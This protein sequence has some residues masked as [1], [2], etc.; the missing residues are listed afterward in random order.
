M[1]AGKLGGY[2]KTFFPSQPVK[3]YSRTFFKPD[4]KGIVIKYEN[5]DWEIR[6]E[7]FTKMDVLEEFLRRN[8]FC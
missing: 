2:T 4:S 7:N 3:E 8:K 5:G 6:D 1:E